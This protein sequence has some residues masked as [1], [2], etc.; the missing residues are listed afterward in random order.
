[1]SPILAAILMPASS[2]TIVVFTT[3]TTKILSKKAGLL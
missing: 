1:L 2:I 3:L